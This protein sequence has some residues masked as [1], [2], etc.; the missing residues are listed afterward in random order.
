MMGRMAKRAV[1]GTRAPGLNVERVGIETSRMVTIGEDDALWSEVDEGDSACIVVGSFVRLQPPPGTSE[2]KLA[3]V[4]AYAKD[5]G[6]AAVK[7][8]PSRRGKVVPGAAVEPAPTAPRKS[9]R[10]AVLDLVEASALEPGEKRAL[11]ECCESVMSTIG[12]F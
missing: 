6:A 1:K 11:R 4:L 12:G 3:E 5:V 2:A 7:V 10:Q 9:A 8:I